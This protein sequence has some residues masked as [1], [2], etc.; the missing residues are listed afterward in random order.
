MPKHPVPYA[1]CVALSLLY[2]LKSAA[3][4]E[5][6]SDSSAF[7]V[8]HTFDGNEFNGRVVSQ[9]SSSIVL[10]T[11]YFGVVTIRKAV[12]RSIR[13][14]SARKMVNGKYWFD[15]PQATRYFAGSN[16]YGLQK[17][18]GM[19][20]N[21]W[22][23]FNQVTYAFSNQ[24]SM[25]FGL[26]PLFVVDGPF[27]VWIMPKISVPVIKD[28]INVGIGGIYGHTF[29]PIY[30]DENGSF[31]VLF[32]QLTFGSRDANGTIGFGYGLSESGWSNA[33]LFAVSGLVRV[34]PKA[35]L[36]TDN[37]FFQADGEG[38]AIFTFG[39][40]AIGRRLLFDIGVMLPVVD[41]E[42]TLIPWLGMHVPF[43]SPK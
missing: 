34:G 2:A 23:F 19:Y 5:H 9:D 12:V 42:S 29:D 15:S 21:G 18:E 28:K 3:Q 22:L 32:S 7:A 41:S 33:P 27:P 20:E 36:I 26:A 31:G 30:D 10:E 8:V 16:G 6:P 35:A 1:L 4:T 13:P 38:L 25:S 14:Y 37:Y 11:A 43:G 17:G 39:A 24:F 40:R